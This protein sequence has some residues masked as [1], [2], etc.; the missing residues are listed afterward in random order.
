MHKCIRKP[1]VLGHPAQCCPCLDVLSPWA[2]LIVATRAAGG[3]LQWNCRARESEVWV[4]GPRGKSRLPGGAGSFRGWPLAGGGLSLAR[5]FGGADFVSG[6]PPS[7][8]ALCPR[9]CSPEAGPGPPSSRGVYSSHKIGTQL[10]SCST[11]PRHS[12]TAA[13]GFPRCRSRLQERASPLEWS[14]A[15]DYGRALA[16]LF[17]SCNLDVAAGL[18][19]DTRQSSS[20]VD[21]NM[22][23]LGQGPPCRVS[24]RTWLLLPSL[25]KAARLLEARLG[26]DH[27]SLPV[28]PCVSFSKT[29]WPARCHGI[30]FLAPRARARLANRLHP[31]RGLC[32]G[33]PSKGILL[34]AL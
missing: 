8:C 34:L 9:R 21:S 20:T 18:A 4:A 29:L 31:L 19:I 27:V 25:R 33:R 17:R 5:R 2:P 16:G 32:L 3:S 14:A 24:S 15:S 22:L 23:N 1:C 26:F 30:P 6:N 28:W 7:T 13:W 12:P 11:T 10:R